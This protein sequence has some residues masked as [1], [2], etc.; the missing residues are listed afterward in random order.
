MRDDITVSDLEI[1]SG[2]VNYRRWLFGQVAPFVGR[3]VLE[4]GAGIGNYTE[5]LLDRELVVCLEIHA[6]ATSRLMER[7]AT[8]PHILVY[9]GDITDTALRSLAQHRCDTA[10]CFNVLEHV[11]DDMVALENIG[12][13]LEPGGRL[14]LIVPANPALMGTVDQSLGHYRRYTAS[15]VRY[16]LVA[17]GYKVE[18]ISYINFLGIFGW[19]WNNRI[20]KRKEESPAQIL[21]YD[22]FIVPWLS[23]LERL[24]PPP[25]GLSLVCIAQRSASSAGGVARKGSDSASVR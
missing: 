18:R 21:L 14:L 17:A 9:Q 25:V 19:L 7:F 12:H 13:I 23:R 1:M 10:L 6:A 3:R 16:A 24:L 4:I 2:A 15:T 20:I 11:K 8:H 5:F 22:R